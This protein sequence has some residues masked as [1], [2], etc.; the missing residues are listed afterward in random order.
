MSALVWRLTTPMRA[1]ASTAL[2]GGIG[3]C[4]WVLNA[5][6]ASDYARTD[7]AAHL[8]ELARML[9]CNGPG[10]GFLTAAR[11][12]RWTTGSDGGVDAYATVGVRLPIW[13]AVP[14]AVAER[15][16]APGTI[17]IVAFSPVALSDAALVNAVITVT[18]AKTQALLEHDVDGTGTASDA[19]CVL[20]PLDGE[21]EA[22]CGPRSPVGSALARAAY[23]AV[24]AGARGR[25]AG[26]GRDR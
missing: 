8:A 2:G 4:G 13:A 19:V 17:N 24:A 25:A 14:G 11:V 9:R 16:T 7:P 12:D 3:A 5:Q 20:A 22:F 21:T 1:I 26:D 6:V 10:V 15:V 18:E 23:G